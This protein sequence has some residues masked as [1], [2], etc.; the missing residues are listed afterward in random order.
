MCRC[1]RVLSGDEIETYRSSQK[2]TKYK[3]HPRPNSTPSAILSSCVVATIE[4][5]PHPLFQLF[6]LYV[7]VSQ[8]GCLMYVK[9]LF[10]INT[11]RK[12][13]LKIYLFFHVSSLG[14]F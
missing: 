11:S 9:D 6:I 12:N 10:G 13:K 4:F 14:F 1:V 5:T 3:T 8:F 7:Y 2:L